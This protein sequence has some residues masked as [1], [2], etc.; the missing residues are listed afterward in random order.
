[1]EGLRTQA[2]LEPEEGLG[3]AERCAYGALLAEMGYMRG[4]FYFVG[5]YDSRVRP[6]PS[7]VLSSGELVYFVDYL[8]K[9]GLFVELLKL[10]AGV[11][12]R[13]SNR[14]FARFVRR[15]LLRRT[16]APAR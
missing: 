3:F 9:A 4:L 15:R 16:L 6:R 7:H 13:C 10:A 14:R 12:V 8:L 11:G 5:N 2:A 1:M